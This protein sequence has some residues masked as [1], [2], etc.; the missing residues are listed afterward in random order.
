MWGG[1][2]LSV[3]QQGWTAAAVDT[4]YTASPVAAATTISAAWNAAVDVVDVA[5]I[6]TTDVSAAAVASS[7]A[8]IAAP[9]KATIAAQGGCGWSRGKG[10]GLEIE[11]EGRGR[12]W[13]R[14]VADTPCMGQAQQGPKL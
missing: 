11:K 1:E 6:A 4:A 10:A 7:P 5:S 12:G 2:P 3:R 8:A 13:D 9:A 14:A